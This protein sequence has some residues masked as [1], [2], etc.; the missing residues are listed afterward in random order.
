MARPRK[1]FGMQ[2]NAKQIRL[3]KEALQ[4]HK[5]QLFVNEHKFPGYIGRQLMGRRLEIAG[6]EEHINRELKARR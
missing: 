1:P 5:T 4:A 6:L 3:I 2:F